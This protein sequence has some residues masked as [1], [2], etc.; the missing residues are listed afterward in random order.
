MLKMSNGNYSYPI[1]ANWSIKDLETV[2]KMFNVV[3]R[4]YEEGAQREQ[5]LDCY[6][7]FKKVIPAK[8]EE[9]QL[10]RDFYKKSGYQLYS[11]VKE[12]RTTDKKLIR[13][14]RR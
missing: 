13:L 8:S 5:I 9:K 10:G 14:S 4:A 3:E 1:D 7:N 6:R 11:V 12:A 2:I